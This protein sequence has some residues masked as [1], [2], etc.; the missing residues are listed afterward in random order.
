MRL[1]LGCTTLVCVLVLI[2]TGCARQRATTAADAEGSQEMTTGI[3]LAPDFRIPDI[4]VPAGFEFDRDHSFVF[5][6]SM[7]DVGKIQYAG[8]EPITD[9]AQF[10]IEEMP[11]YNWTLLNVAEHQTVALFF[12]K[13]NKSCQVLLTPKVRGTEIQI[14]FFPKAVP[15]PEQQQQQY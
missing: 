2:A 11:R 1:K 14:S 12:D 5:Q 4:P 7:L 15:A 9:V 10:Y 3:P 6:N 8:K 13:E